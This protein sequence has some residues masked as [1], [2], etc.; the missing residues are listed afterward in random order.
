MVTLLRSVRWLSRDDLSTR[1][2]HAGP[3]LPVEGARQLGPTTFRLALLPYAG[4]WQGADVA[5]QAQEHAAPIQ[6]VTSNLTEGLLDAC[7]SFFSLSPA[8]VVLTS[9]T[10]GPSGTLDARIV[11]LDHRPVYARIK[12]P[13]QAFPIALDG[14]RLDGALELDHVAL[15]PGEIL[16]LRLKMNPASS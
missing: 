13:I 2:G 5:R 1:R 9:M 12:G 3:A 4:R 7:G 15:R 11:N 6:I 8:S 14:R 16:S 10:Q